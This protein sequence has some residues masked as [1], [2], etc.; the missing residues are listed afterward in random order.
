MQGAG[1]SRPETTTIDLH[2]PDPA[3]S[4]RA[5]AAPTKDEIAALPPFAGLPLARIRV[6]ETPDEHDAAVAAIVAAAT[7]GFDTES[8]PVF[9]VGVVNEGPHVVQFATIDTAWVFQLHRDASRSA[10]A[11]LLASS[12]VIKVGF[13]LSSD[14]RHIR[15]KFG[16]EPQAIV[17][18]DH[19]FRDRGYRKSIGV[20]AA[21]AILFGE[22]LQKSKRQTTSNWAR[23]LLDERQLAYAANDAYAAFRVHDKLA[24]LPLVSS[25]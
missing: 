25:R 16:I 8:K 2:L 13:G 14:L 19:A 21:I 5:A 9:D 23:P 10:V 20:R 15:A 1:D 6:P 4:G 7:V 12:D 3:R 24:A 22:R 18:L 17:D 11:A